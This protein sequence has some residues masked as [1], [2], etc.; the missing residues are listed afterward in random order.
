MSALQER[1]IVLGVSGSIACYKAADIASKL[2][3]AG[4]LVDVLLTFSAQRFVTPL[5]FRSLTHRPVV[6]DLFD[7]ESE[8]EVEHVALAER[9]DVVLI[10]PATAH[11]IAKL[12]AGLVDDALTATVLATTAPVLLAPAMDAKMYEASVTQDNIR[13]LQGRGYRFVGPGVGRLASGLTG[14]GRLADTLE[15]LAALEE[16]LTLRRDLDGLRIVVSAGGTQEA[17]DPVR[18]ITNRSSGK[19]GYGI[20]QA[21]RDRGAQVSL[22]TAPTALGNV[23]GVRMVHVNSARQML[24]AVQEEVRGADGL[25][26]A[27]AVAD[28]EPIDVAAQK[29]KKVEGQERLVLELQKTPDIL[30]EVRNEP[31]V[32]VGF[33]AESEDLI[34][35]ATDKLRK[36]NLDFIVANDITATD[37]GF[38]ADT[39]RVVILD[40]DGGREDLPLM[41]KEA[42][43][44]HILDRIKALVGARVG[45]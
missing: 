15:V 27:A 30:Y 21:A 43:G 41:L 35:N 22:I 26:M 3:Q 37:A 10:A 14:P 7:P 24:A 6:A 23:S 44:D 31:L 28:W 40:K 32:K 16:V 1:D 9:A 4:A 38:N 29:M 5:T 19:Q 33:A 12:A 13:K 18:H 42:V 17:I 11:V 2:A 25:I 34:A 8:L 39:N 36:K 20:A 45:R